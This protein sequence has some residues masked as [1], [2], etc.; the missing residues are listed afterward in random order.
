MNTQKVAKEYRLS[1]W[2]QIIQKRLESGE[3]VKDFCQAEGINKNQYF[4]WQR[5]LRELACTELSNAERLKSS[6][7]KGW[8]KLEPKVLEPSN[9]SLNIEVNCCHIAVN[10]HTDPEL[11][12]KVCR[13]LRSL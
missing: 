6:V 8:M 1:Q 4:Y 2:A 13:I 12:K 9:E 3:S 11:L 5:K 10:T 7:P